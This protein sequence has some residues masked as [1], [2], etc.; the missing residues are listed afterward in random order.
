MCAEAQIDFSD[1]EWKNKYK[2]DFEQRFHLPHLTDI[3][4]DLKPI[5]STFCLK[6]R[7]FSKFWSSALFICCFGS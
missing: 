3:F 2:Q 6:M 5:P 1:P 7:Y 4:K